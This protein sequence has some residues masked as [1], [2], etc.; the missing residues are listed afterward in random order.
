MVDGGCEVGRPLPVPVVL[1]LAERMRV[2]REV[3]EP[4]PPLTPL[5]VMPLH[6]GPVED[7]FQWACV[8]A[9]QI[10]SSYPDAL[11]AVATVPQYDWRCVDCVRLAAESVDRDGDRTLSWAPLPSDPQRTATLSWLV[12]RSRRLLDVPGLPDGWL[13]PHACEN[14]HPEP[15]PAVAV[16][17]IVESDSHSNGTS[18]CAA[19]LVG[20]WVQFIEE[21]IGQVQA[22]DREA[23][24]WEFVPVQPPVTCQRHTSRTGPHHEPGC[25]S[26]AEVLDGVTD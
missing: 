12:A 6:G 1:P 7:G 24:S 23:Y 5:D 11:Q 19:C 20:G 14:E 2:S 9:E 18:L 26:Y 15:Q 25:A 22:A 10:P 8:R 16:V 21:W 4:Y 3:V 17:Y 13:A